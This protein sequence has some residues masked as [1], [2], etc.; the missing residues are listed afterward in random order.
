MVTK[1]VRR[2][3]SRR[4]LS[5]AYDSKEI[6]ARVRRFYARRSVRAAISKAVSRSRPVGYVE[7][8]PTLNN[9]PH[10]G[11]VRGRMMKDLWYRYRTLEGENI[12]F[13]G[14]W[15]TQGLP[16]ELQA[17]K[18][19]GLSGNKWEDLE[20]VGVD[21]LVA[22]C[23]EIIGKYKRD[24]EEAD[25]LLGL[26]IDHEHAYM[27]YRDS[28]IE[29]EW[30]YLATAW[31]RGLLG[32]GFKVVPYC[33]ECQTA[34]SAG[35]VSLGGYEKLEDPSLYYKAKT[36][37]GAYLILWTTMPFTVVTDELVGA[38]P[39]S[40]YEYVRVGPETWVVNSGRKEALAKELGVEFGETVRRVKGEELEGLRYE[41]PLLDQIPGLRKPEFEGKIHKVV[42]EEY[43]DITAGTGLVHMSPANGEEDFAAA[44]KRSVPVFAPFDDRVKFTQ[45]AGRFAGMFARDS[46]P[47]V[48]EALGEKGA[49]VNAGK[50]VHDYPV[51]WRSNDRLVWL[52]RREY[53]YWVDR[54]RSDV[55]KAAEK[56]EYFF[57]GP[58]NRFLAGLA[59]SPAWCVTRERIWGNPLPIW[60][61]EKCGEKTPAF[62]RAEILRH[63]AELPDGP[64][65][66][67]HRPWIDRVVLKCQK[68][69]GRALREP[70]VLDTW[71]NSG[72]SPYASFTDDEFERLVPVGFL[73]EGIDQTRGWAYTLLLLNVIRSGKPLAPYRMFLFQG[74]VLDEKGE[75]M[76]KSLGNFIGGLDVLRNYS[77]DGARLYL[78]SKASPEDSVSVDLKEMT[79]RPYQVLN[80]LYH[81]HVYLQ[82]NGAVDGYDVRKHTVAWAAKKRLLTLVDRWM[83]AKL[84]DA[85]ERVVGAYGDAR[86]NEAAKAV[87]ELVINHLSQTYVRLVRNELWKDDPRERGR[88]LAIYAVL[89]EGLRK[90]DT[91]LHPVSP[92]VTEH[93]YQELFAPRAWE[94][95]LLAAGRETTRVGGSKSAEETVDFALR[96][97]EACNSAREKA[98][99]KRRW[100]LREVRV[101]VRP[102]SVGVAKRARGTVSLLCNVKGVAVE[103][104]VSRFPATFALKP[105]T[106][107]VGALFREKTRDVLAS[108]KTMQGSA[109]L[110]AYLS[111]KP[112]RAGAFEVPLSVFELVTT[113]KDGFEVAERGGVFVSLPKQR[114]QKLVAEGLVRD[115]ARRLQAL[116]KEK[117]YVPTALLRSASVAGLEEEDVEMV[118]PLAK[119]MAYLVRVRGVE[120]AT[121]KPGAKGWSEAELDGRPIY[122]KVG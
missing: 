43:V 48:I 118:R 98:K 29:R 66:E 76:S 24:W 18:E 53:F 88:R 36:E 85:E 57:D 64:G 39:G 17:E 69:G 46:D 80:T 44:Q 92:F 111:G 99:L 32:E 104:S 26:M 19:L 20:K 8:P 16:V 95:P 25:R 73:T 34:L 59:E 9:Q 97:E 21:K 87:E 102:S 107:R 77:V 68:C 65:F 86:F 89:G 96:V 13:R 7:G 1:L 27:T 103:T 2:S 54:I 61:C 122:L 37:D 3:R 115:L 90:S 105:N 120:I 45:E 94:K 50:I 116:R 51:C 109:A 38:K 40:D 11:H 74:H 112:V 5:T 23:K 42:A 75:K 56:V 91:L 114:D 30:S 31:K 81:L 28:Y 14:G 106:S 52:A 71:H 100:P 83:L 4:P 101:L 117:G 47:V 6:E 10:I 79:G 15:D 63:A 49:L 58:K 41:H 78:L 82:Q 84:A 72:A 55:V 110:R 35:E 22:A 108:L 33:P 12:V 121:G 93:L 62:S 67:L 113:P 70:F 119:Q 60:V